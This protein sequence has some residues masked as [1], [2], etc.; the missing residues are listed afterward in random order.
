MKLEEAGLLM[1]PFCEASFLMQRDGNTMAHVLLL[2]L[3]LYQPV[4]QF[5]PGKSRATQLLLL[6]DMNRRWLRKEQPLHFLAFALHPS[7]TA[8][9]RKMIEQSDAR[10]TFLEGNPL[11]YQRLDGVAT[12]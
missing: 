2:L 1:R 7:F 3:N 9:A 5:R 11:T 10:G 4:K 12:F 6:K 8:C